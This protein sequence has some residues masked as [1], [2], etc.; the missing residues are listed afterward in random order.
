MTPWA[1]LAT[2]LCALRSAHV[3]SLSTSVAAKALAV[4]SFL[5]LLGHTSFAIPQDKMSTLHGL[6]DLFFLGLLS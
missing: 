1:F 3:V 2:S 5:S 6:P 4:W